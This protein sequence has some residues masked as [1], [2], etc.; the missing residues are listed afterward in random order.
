MTATTRGDEIKMKTREK[1]ENL[2]R[3]KEILKNL[4][5]PSNCKCAECPNFEMCLQSLQKIQQGKAV[6]RAISRTKKLKQFPEQQQRQE[7]QKV[8]SD[9]EKD[10]KN[11]ILS[12]SQQV[13]PIL[14]VATRALCDGLNL[15]ILNWLKK[16]GFSSSR[17]RRRR[18]TGK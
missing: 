11:E 9:L 6:Q 17:L 8:I 3:R 10:L 4:G 13:N 14:A 5:L 12:T 2:Y 18:F 15:V 1:E 7:A 16:Q